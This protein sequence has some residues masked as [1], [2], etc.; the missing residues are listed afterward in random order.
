MRAHGSGL[1]SRSLGWEFG[2]R[3]YKPVAQ[4][5]AVMG[6]LRPQ[7]CLCPKWAWHVTRVQYH[8]HIHPSLVFRASLLGHLGA[9]QRHP[10]V[11]TLLT[12]SLQ[13]VTERGER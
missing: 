4:C 5:Q 8:A 10:F 9:D 6:V 1:G 3:A 13:G 12:G 7:W 11:E 2:Q